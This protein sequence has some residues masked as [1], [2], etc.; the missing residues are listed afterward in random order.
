M[1]KSISSP[2]IRATTIW[3]GGAA[4]SRQSALMAI[5]FPVNELIF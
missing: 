3:H 4:L 1:Q 2:Q 5:I